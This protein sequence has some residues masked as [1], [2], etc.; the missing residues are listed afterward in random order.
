MQLAAAAVVAA[1]ESAA[2]A[3]DDASQLRAELKDLRAVAD[4]APPPAKPAAAQTGPDGR[5]PRFDRS[6]R[7]LG[8]CS[9]TYP[10]RGGAPVALNPQLLALVALREITIGVRAPK[11]VLS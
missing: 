1:A 9:V 7:A 6:G 3:R 5:V 11:G 4:A 2:T 10:G 8:V